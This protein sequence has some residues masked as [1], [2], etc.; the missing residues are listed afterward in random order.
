MKKIRIWF[1]F[2]KYGYEQVKSQKSNFYI[3]ICTCKEGKVIIKISKPTH[4]FGVAILNVFNNMSTLFAEYPNLFVH[5]RLMVPSFTTSSYT[6]FPCW[7]W[8]FKMT[9]L[10]LFK[11][12]YIKIKKKKQTCIKEKHSHKKKNF[13]TIYSCHELIIQT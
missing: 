12:T 1:F 13:H 4:K 5:F 2:Y 3:H 6:E 10:T 11:D 7:K 9:I 8:V